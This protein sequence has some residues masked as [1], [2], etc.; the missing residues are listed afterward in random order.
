M[1]T[2]SS[3]GVALVASQAS[4]TLRA[5]QG[6]ML[7]A[8]QTVPPSAPPRTSQGFMLVATK[9]PSKAVLE[10]GPITPIWSSNSSNQTIDPFRIFLY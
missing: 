8:A 1:T 2:R 3:Q 6:F 9:K 5:S 7:V 4:S 10:V